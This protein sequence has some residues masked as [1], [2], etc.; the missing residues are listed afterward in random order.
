MKNIHTIIKKTVLSLLLFTSIYSSAQEEK[1][2]DK[3]QIVEISCGQCQ[4]DVT[5]KKGCDL[6]IRI[7][8][9]SYFVDGTTIDSHGDAH[10]KDGFCNTVR[11]AVVTGK[12]VRN[13]FIVKTFKLLP[14][15]K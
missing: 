10:S 14:I 13:R 1:K 7:N 12:L 11:K 9:K 15:E 4:F 6:A 2:E 5:N 8:G 3:P